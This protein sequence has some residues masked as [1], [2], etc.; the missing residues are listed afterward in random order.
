MRSSFRKGCSRR[1]GENEAAYRYA[2]SKDLSRFLTEA[3]ARGLDLTPAIAYP[4][5][6]YSRATVEAVRDFG[7]LA[8]FTCDERVNRLTGAEGELLQLGRFN[9]PHGAAG[10]KIFALWEENC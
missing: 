3:E 6:A 8:A 2:L 7:F 9:R 4:Y 5:G 1:A 10:E